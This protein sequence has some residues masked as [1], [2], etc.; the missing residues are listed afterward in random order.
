MW[1]Q[2]MWLASRLTTTLLDVHD[3]KVAND[4]DDG[5]RRR[6]RLRAVVSISGGGRGWRGR[7]A[8]GYVDD[9]DDR[10]RG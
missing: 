2:Q 6:L 1:Q 8:G 9:V 7:T 4:G 3:V 5:G 10:C